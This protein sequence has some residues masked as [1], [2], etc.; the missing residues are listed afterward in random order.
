MK[1]QY[2]A[3]TKEGELQ[4]GFIE[5]VNREAAI[6]ILVGHELFILS[7]QEADKPHW[8][9]PFLRLVNRVKTTD[10]MVFTRQFATLLDAKIS[11]GDALKNLRRQTANAILKEVI[12]DLSSDIDSGLLLSQAMERHPQVFSNFYVSMVRSAEVTGRLEEV[13][14]FMADY[15]EKESGLMSRVRGAM[16]YPVVLMV[17]F[18]VVVGI[19]VGVVF[20]QLEPVFTESNA[21]IPLVTQVLL[22]LGQFIANW[23]LAILIVLA[24]V[25]VVLYDYFDTPEGKVVLDEFRVRLPIIGD[26]YRKLYVSRFAE[27]SAVL[28]RGGIPIAQALEISGHTIGSL[29]YRDALHEVAEAVRS[30]QLMSQALAAHEDFFPPLVHQMVAVGESTG[31]LEQLLT[32]VSGFYSREVDNTVSNLV[33]LI[34]PIL[35]VIMGVMVGLLF[36]AVLLPIYNLAQTF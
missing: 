36:A 19:M 9:D 22:G 5:A 25:G 30:G 32:R 17:L 2:T 13:M 33:E 7:V 10:L 28:I 8:Y 14:G 35:M 16:I 6:N 3:R 21:K 31:K 4:T 24:I 29:I 12:S 26:M 15:L 11:L 27:S 23:W 20:P 18:A 34:Q 1:F